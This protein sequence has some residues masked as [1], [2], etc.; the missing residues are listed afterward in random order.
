MV[1]LLQ[2]QDNLLFLIG[3]SVGMLLTSQRDNDT[4]VVLLLRR[5]FI[6]S[7][8]SSCNLNFGPLAPEVDAGG[9]FDQ[10]DD[11]GTTHTGSRFEEV[12]IAIIALDELHMHH[13]T[14]H[15]KGR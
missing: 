5:Q 11:V 9:S 15:A 14:L 2:P 13:S 12:K 3:G 10:I 8:L 1:P 6:V 7:P 4:S